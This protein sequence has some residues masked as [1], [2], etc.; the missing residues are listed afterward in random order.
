M[1]EPVKW[2][3]S[4]NSEVRADAVKDANDLCGLCL[5]KESTE[6]GT[7]CLAVCPRNR[8]RTKKVALMKQE[9]KDVGDDIRS[10]LI[11]TIKPIHVS[12]FDGKIATSCECRSIHIRYVAWEIDALPKQLF[13]IDG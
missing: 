1:I 4:S 3:Y 8:G 7:Y 2:R 10:R 13:T 12:E 11:L 5:A 9:D 6:I